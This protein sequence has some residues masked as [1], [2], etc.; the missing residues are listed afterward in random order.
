MH[1]NLLR[2]GIRT[3]LFALSVVSL[4]GSAIS[5]NAESS[6]Q[7][8][9]GAMAPILVSNQY[10]QKNLVANKPGI[11]AVTDP[12]L[13]NAWGLSRSSGNPWWVSD[14][15]TGVSTLYDGQGAI[16]QLVVGIPP[17]NPNTASTGTPTGT[18]FNG[19]PDFA[20]KPG[21]PS[22]FLFVAE[23][24]VISG[25]NPG[26]NLYK[27]EILVNHKDKSV[28]KG[29]SIATVNR[30]EWGTR[31]FLYVADFRQ[32]RV[33]V[34]D[35]NFKETPSIEAAFRSQQHVPAGYAPF[36]VQ[37]IGGNL[38]VSYGKQDAAKHDEI[39]GA[40][41]GIVLVFSPTGQLIQRLQQGPWLDAP[42]GMAQAPSDFGPYSHDILIGNFG[43]GR[44]AAYDP[45]TGRFRDFLRDA[46]S[47]PIWIDGLWA[48]AFGNDS[49]A[50]PATTLYFTAG[51]NHEQDGL[52][53]S[54][55]ALKNPFGN[56]Q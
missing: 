24:G 51:P 44:I 45:V 36:N 50:G 54:L 35:T 47:A 55:M 19:T 5:Q 12:N 10:Q 28:F 7:Q 9:A 30:A 39:H 16:Q 2:H 15:G 41:L 37:N 40:G 33:E 8:S 22:I 20:I 25:W 31:N 52:F 17:S 23:D 46:K 48:L 11:A 1:Q 21:M 49:V 14:N 3:T 13:V 53:G 43:S 6:T 26:I 29:A 27:A 32:A 38:Y 42:W 34:F 56:S 4:A 18:V